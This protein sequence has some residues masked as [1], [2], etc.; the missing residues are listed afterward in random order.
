MAGCSIAM[1]LALIVAAAPAQDCIFK[2]KDDDSL[3]QA[4][5][6]FHD[7][8]AGLVH[9]PAEK[10]DFAPVR[11]QAEELARLRTG[12]MAASLPPKLAK[13]C[14]DLSARAQELSRAVDSRAMRAKEKA[15]A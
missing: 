12:I 13:R 1:G 6:N 15:P 2:T 4:L 7:V 10:G 8:L 3:K 11:A 14:P 9:G 5:K